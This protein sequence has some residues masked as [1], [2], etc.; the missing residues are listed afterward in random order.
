MKPLVKGALGAFLEEWAKFAHI[1]VKQESCRQTIDTIVREA[2][3]WPSRDPSK[4]RSKDPIDPV[5]AL[6]RLT[7]VM[8]GLSTRT[9]SS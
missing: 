8:A 5:D 7:T 9:S 1:D 2:R 3:P 4:D 6:T